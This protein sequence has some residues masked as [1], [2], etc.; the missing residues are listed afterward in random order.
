M[1]KKDS[2]RR[3]REGLETRHRY[4]ESLNQARKT[5]KRKSL[6]L[7]DSSSS[8]RVEDEEVIIDTVSPNPQI[9]SI[10]NLL[11][12]SLNEFARYKMFSYDLNELVVMNPNELIVLRGYRDAQI[13]KLLD[14]SKKLELNVSKIFKRK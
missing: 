9:P 13:Q 12:E 5:E 6:I 3:T 7:G 11:K 14:E 2:S 4:F 10:E 1:E 8:P